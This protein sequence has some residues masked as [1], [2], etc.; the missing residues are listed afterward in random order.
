MAIHPTAVIDSKAELDSTVEVGPFCVIEGNVRVAAGCRLYPGVYLTGWT[1]IGE[2]CTLHPNVIVGHEAQD[3]KYGGERTYCR[4]GRGTILR[5]SVTIHRGSEPESCTVVGEKCFL[6]AGSH[7][8]HNATVGNRVTM[9]NNVLIGGHAHI[10][11]A[12]TLGGTAGVHQ[13]VRVGELAMVAGAARVCQDIP[14]FA[15]IGVD[16]RVAG[17]NRVGL[18]RAGFEQAQVAEIRD[19]FR[20]LYASGKSMSAAIEELAARDTSGPTRTLVEFLKEKSRRGL[21]GRSR[22]S[23]APDCSEAST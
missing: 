6:L 16:G 13:F 1:E 12:V 21:A 9:I 10:A 8:G 23:Q 5:E 15:L 18:R 11:D 2:D 22:S 20:V 17:L 7:V 3:I 4:V 14:P 19:V